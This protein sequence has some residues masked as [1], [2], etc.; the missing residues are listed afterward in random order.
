MEFTTAAELFSRITLPVLGYIQTVILL[1]FLLPG[2]AILGYYSGR[3]RTKAGPGGE[4][5]GALVGEAT[6]G[7]IMS[8]LGLLLAFTFANAVVVSQ[9]RTQTINDEAAAIGTAF[10]RADYLPDPGRSE[11]QQAILDYAETRVTTGGDPIRS[12]G[13]AQAFIETSLIAQG[14]LWPQTLEATSDP[15]PAATKSF[16]A[17][18]VNE[19]L[20][21][22]LDR[23]QSLSSPISTLAQ[24]MLLSIALVALFLLGNRSGVAGRPLTWRTFLFAYSLFAIMVTITDI[25]RATEGFVTVNDTTLKATIFEMT[26]SMSE[27]S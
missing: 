1:L 27:R 3:G 17:S 20:D 25:Q 13:Q 7:A 14:E 26:Q 24:G 4:P 22:H 12:I 9:Q 6:L 16:V 10:L 19:V 8:L 21:S 23:I 18:A 5:A 15:V 2:A 11:L